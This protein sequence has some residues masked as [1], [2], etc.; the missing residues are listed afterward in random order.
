MGSG[1]VGEMGRRYSDSTEAK[2]VILNTSKTCETGVRS[3][4]KKPTSVGGSIIGF[5][6]QRCPAFNPIHPKTD[7]GRGKGEPDQV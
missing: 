6:S 3:E 7:D 1:A 2:G 4:Q 5:S